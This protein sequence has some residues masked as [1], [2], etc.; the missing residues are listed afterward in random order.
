MAHVQN[1][2]C[3]DIELLACDSAVRVG[4]EKSGEVRFLSLGML[5]GKE[6]TLNEF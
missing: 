2:Q 4:T 1:G 5:Q 6:R 3:V